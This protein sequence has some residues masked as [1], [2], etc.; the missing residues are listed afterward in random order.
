MQEIHEAWKELMDIYKEIEL[1]NSQYASESDN[2]INID[3]SIRTYFF[4]VH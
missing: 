3:S 1:Y 2:V 4:N